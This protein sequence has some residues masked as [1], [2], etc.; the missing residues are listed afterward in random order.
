MKVCA[1]VCKK[2]P[3]KNNNVD[4]MEKKPKMSLFSLMMLHKILVFHEIFNIIYTKD[5]SM[6]VKI[7]VFADS[8]QNYTSIFCRRLLNA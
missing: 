8:L 2:P 6:L 4:L 1:F 5:T 3:L 7:L